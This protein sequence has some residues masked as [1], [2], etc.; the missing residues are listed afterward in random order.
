MRELSLKLRQRAAVEWRAG[1][2]SNELHDLL[3][4]AA[5]YIESLD[6]CTRCDTLLEPYHHQWT[7]RDSGL[8][9]TPSRCA[10]MRSRGLAE[11]PRLRVERLLL[12]EEK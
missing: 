4:E 3:R 2:E 11:V 1:S 12:P 8:E 5:E 10:E 9:H 7:E 6:R